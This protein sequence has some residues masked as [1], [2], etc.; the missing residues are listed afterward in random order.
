MFNAIVF[1][2]V[3][4]IAVV[5]SVYYFREKKRER[6]SQAIMKQRLASVERIKSGFK[7]DL[8]RLTELG[9]LSEPAQEAIYRLA[10][11]YFVFQPASAENLARCEMTLKELLMAI[12]NKMKDSDNNNN[13]VFIRLQL[14]DFAKSLP[15]QTAGYNVGFY[16]RELPLLIQEFVQ[17]QGIEEQGIRKLQD[18]F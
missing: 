17:A 9:V 18:Y 15:R 11:Y 2:L 4:V 8:Q 13:P 10:S 16:H 1:I 6:A 5:F 3:L 7:G 12:R 14:D